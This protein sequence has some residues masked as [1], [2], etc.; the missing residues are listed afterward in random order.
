MKPL[1]IATYN[2]LLS[3]LRKVFIEGL[4]KIEQERGLCLLAHR[5]A[6]RAVYP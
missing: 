1:V 4:E 3:Q 2:Q 6:D 5:K